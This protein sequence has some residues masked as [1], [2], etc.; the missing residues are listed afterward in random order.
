[1]SSIFD[2]LGID[3]GDVRWE[4][5]ALCASMAPA[6][7]TDGEGDLFFEKY[8]TSPSTAKMVDEL[9]L[10]CPV[11]KQCLQSGIDDKLTGVRGGI[12]LT[13]GKRNIKRNAHKTEAV[14]NQI[15]ERLGNPVH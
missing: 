4:D 5:L 10:S 14:W 12:Y 8:E 7:G 3:P 11:M 15:K 9:C 6:P 2:L 13:D 1:M